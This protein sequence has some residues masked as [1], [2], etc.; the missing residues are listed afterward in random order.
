MVKGQIQLSGYAE[1]R[2]R[3]IYM[4]ALDCYQLVTLYADWLK[5]R[6]KLKTIGDV[7]VLTT[8]FI[9]RHNDYLQ[10]YVKATPS[11]MLLTDDGYTIRFKGITKSPFRE[12]AFDS[13]PE[14]DI[15]IVLE[16]D[17]KVLKWVRPPLNQMPIFYKGGN[18]NPDF[19]VETGDKKYIVEVK[20]REEID[21][22]KTAVKE[23]AKSAIKWCEIATEVEKSKPWE[24]KL[25]PDD[26]IRTTSD[27]AF[28]ASQAVVLSRD[29]TCWG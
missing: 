6:V 27:F 14:K 29:Q 13:V 3:F 16:D 22:P 10:I 2:K 11:G 1:Y 19:I 21:D 26:T 25:I 24:Y 9:D 7:C 5:E 17:L 28:I 15:A 4:S 23:K 12:V 8:P 18:Y 20:A